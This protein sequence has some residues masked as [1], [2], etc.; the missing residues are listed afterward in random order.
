MQ[1]VDIIA[2]GNRQRATRAA[3]ADDGADDRHF[4]LGELVKV[5]A[6]GF[7][8][9]ALFG[10][11]AG[12][13][14]GGINESEHRQAEFF[15]SLHQAQGFAVALGAR[16][17]EVAADFFFGVAAFL[18]ADDDDALAV[19]AR[20]PAD[21]G[22]VVGEM[23]V[24]V[25]LLEIGAQRGNIVES[26]GTLRVA[27]N[28]R[29]LRGR[30]FAENGFG[31]IAAF[32]LQTGDFVGNIDRRIVLYQAQFFDFFCQFGNRLFKV[33]KNGFHYGS[34]GRRGGRRCG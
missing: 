28:L 32:F 14:A 12:V 29:N 5:A 23:A 8:L 21:D 18:V 9:V 6:D 10:A 20:Q 31:Q 17:A 4:E 16:H 25:Q 1:H 11:D 26:V 34:I 30:E 13:G 3:F 22:V 24:A 19:K 7:G 2:D 15:G 27:R 33:E